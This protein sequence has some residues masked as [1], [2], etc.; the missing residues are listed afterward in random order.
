M[1]SEL[2]WIEE[3]SGINSTKVSSLDQLIQLALKL[4]QK[5]LWGCYGE[6]WGNSSF[7]A[8]GI[9]YRGQRIRV[10]PQP[11]I[12]HCKPS[13]TLDG[14]Y[15]EVTLFTDFRARLGSRAEMPAEAEALPWMAIMRHY[16]LPN[17]VLD[18]SKSMLVALLFALHENKDA[19]ADEKPHLWVLNARAL[20]EVTH[21]S[22]YLEHPLKSTSK[23][24]KPYIWY[25]DSFPTVMRAEQVRGRL[26]HQWFRVLKHVHPASRGYPS[27]HILDELEALLER[28]KDGSKDIG[29]FLAL[30]QSQHP[31]FNNLLWRLVT[32]GAVQPPWNNPRILA[33]KGMLTVHGG[34]FSNSYR[35]A[36]KNIRPPAIDL[37]YVVNKCAAP[38]MILRRIDLEDTKNLRSEINALGWEYSDLMPETEHQVR[39][40]RDRHGDEQEF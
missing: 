23:P 36:D 2:I 33:Q 34:A 38:G 27:D 22:Y 21:Y 7:F 3:E 8:N 24:E 32:P 37:N 12:F 26:P 30:I 17:R 39:A 9:W 4:A 31:D 5:D 11:S 29:S 16:D 25:P 13:G 20:N 10:V 6:N 35:Y 14:Q 15:D 1:T 18:W 28:W 40:I 19:K